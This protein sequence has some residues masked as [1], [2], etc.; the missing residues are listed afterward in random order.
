M[1]DDLKGMNAF[2]K[3][4]NFLSR[5]NIAEIWM[6]YNGYRKL[7]FLAESFFKMPLIVF[8][9]KKIQMLKFLLRTESFSFLLLSTEVSILLDRPYH[10]E[11]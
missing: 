7:I 11:G 9:L 3:V 1:E 10:C 6:E 2:D 8:S 4:I 5:I